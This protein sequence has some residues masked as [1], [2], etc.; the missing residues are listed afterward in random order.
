MGGQFLRYRT[1]LGAGCEGNCI[2]SGKNSEAVFKSTL[3]ERLIG[4]DAFS[5]TGHTCYA[6]VCS[7]VNSLN[8]TRILNLTLF[9]PEVSSVVVEHFIQMRVPMAMHES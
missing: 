4:S 7:A 1:V 2:L 8:A 5:E 3:R 6:I 9:H